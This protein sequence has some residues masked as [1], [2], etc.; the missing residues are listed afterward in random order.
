MYFFLGFILVSPQNIIRYFFISTHNMGPA[1]LAFYG[2]IIALPW[3]IKPIYGVISDNT[4]HIVIRRFQIAFGYLLTG[5]C[6]SLLCFFTDVF[7]CVGLTFFSSMF[8]AFSDVVQDSIMVARSKGTNGVVQSISWAFRS[9]GSLFGCI[10]GAVFTFHSNKFAFISLIC[11]VAAVVS[12]FVKTDTDTNIK[13]SSFCKDFCLYIYC[14][15]ILLFSLVIFVYA[16]D[17]GDG[18]IVEY[19]LIQKFNASPSLFALSDMVSYVSL[20][21]ASVIF[22]AYLRDANIFY[23][24]TCTNI[25]ALLMFGFRNAFVTDSIQVEPLWFMLLNSFVYAFIAQ[26]SFLPFIILSTKFSPSGMEGTVYSFFMAISNAAG[27]VSSELSGMLTNVFE[28]KN[29]INFDKN[30]MTNFYIACF[31]MD[32]VGFF[33]IIYLL[34]K[35]LGNVSNVS[36]FTFD[37]SIYDPVDPNNRSSE[38]EEDEGPTLELTV[39]HHKE[40]CQLDDVDL[41][42]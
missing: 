38:E 7:A 4:R 5:L 1:E 11:V 13:S 32:T 6:F 28:I 10:Y 23:I 37:R 34:R 24:I 26:I 19:L 39:P 12:F 17:P 40:D 41:Q 2:G 42:E 16:Y 21:V 15:K 27:I 18:S 14:K 3:S 33:I 35:I 9:A 20:M 30:N 29:N 8:L 36:K 31:S 25:I 22:N